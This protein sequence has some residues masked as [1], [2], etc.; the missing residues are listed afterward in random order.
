MVDVKKN[1]VTKQHEG[2]TR[3]QKNTTRA[4]KKLQKIVEAGQ[5][6][7]TMNMRHTEEKQ[8]ILCK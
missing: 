8:R 5:N 1:N 7:T 2:I 6:V 4:R 3:V